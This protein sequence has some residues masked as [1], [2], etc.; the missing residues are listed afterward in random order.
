VDDDAM[1]KTAPDG[2]SVCAS[3]QVRPDLWML[4]RRTFSYFGREEF[5]VEKFEKFY[6]QLFGKAL[7]L[8]VQE[9][10]ALVPSSWIRPDSSLS[11][12][13][14]TAALEQ[15]ID[16]EDERI[17]ATKGSRP[18]ISEVGWLQVQSERIPAI[19]LLRFRSS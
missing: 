17:M 19:V 9:L 3:P 14:L 5:P 4:L 16:R 13:S 18:H 6:D 11:H 8:S 12:V 10:M 2:A 7:G 1:D 15:E